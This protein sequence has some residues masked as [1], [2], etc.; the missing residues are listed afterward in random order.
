MRRIL[1]RVLIC[2]FDSSRSFQFLPLIFPGLKN[3]PNALYS[4]QNVQFVNH[5]PTAHLPNSWCST[6]NILWQTAFLVMGGVGAITGVIFKNRVKT[7][8]QDPLSIF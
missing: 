4:S 2:A 7:S 3:P 1:H 8:R 6:L 5:T